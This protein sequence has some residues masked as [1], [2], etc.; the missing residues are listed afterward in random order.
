MAYGKS[1]ILGFI[2]GTMLNATVYAAVTVEETRAQQREI[3]RKAEDL[4]PLSASRE[5]FELVDKLIARLNDYPL[6]RKSVV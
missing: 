6:D 1:L 4:L 5:N 2:T 3:Y